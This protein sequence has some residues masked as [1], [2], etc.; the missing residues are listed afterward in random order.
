MSGKNDARPGVCTRTPLCTKGKGHAGWCKKRGSDGDGPQDQGDLLAALGGKMD[1]DEE[2][3]RRQQPARQGSRSSS[4]VE[5]MKDLAARRR[6]GR[7]SAKRKAM[8][9]DEDDGEEDDD[10]EDDGEEE[11]EEEEEEDWKA[12]A[13]RRSKGRV[14]RGYEDGAKTEEG[15]EY[16]DYGMSRKEARAM[17]SGQPSAGDEGDADADG[18]AGSLA[19]WEAGGGTAPLSELEP[20]R[21][22]RQLLERWLLEPFFK[23]V[24]Y[25]CLVRI[26][27]SSPDGNG[28]LYRAAEVTDVQEFPE[29]P[30]ML[31]Q[32][33]TTKRLLLEFGESRQWYPMSSVSNQPLEEI[34]LRSWQQVREVWGVALLSD[35]QLRAKTT[36]LAEASR[37]EYSEADVCKRIE[38]ERKQA[39]Q[40][41]K[42]PALTT[43]QK[44]QS[45]NSVARP[46]KFQ[47]NAFGQ[48]IVGGED[49]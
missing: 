27:L 7:G 15:V 2:L 49:E 18:G 30:Y 41:G 37:Y 17:R 23:K 1:N 47:R 43:R 26:G 22:R 5:A 48:A 36:Q 20:I 44:L 34:E 19:T 33:R 29:H 25:G 31:G 40:G 16:A 14:A 4:K 10:F 11:E 32:R 24:V 21:L 39:A 35:N 46:M 9:E 28:T 42:P 12:P 3:K 45:S 8:D 38:E 13:S 6:E